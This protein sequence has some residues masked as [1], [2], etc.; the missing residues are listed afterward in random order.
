MSRTWKEYNELYYN[1]DFVPT[2]TEALLIQA[3]IF[4]YG[5]Y[6]L[7]LT[8]E[9]PKVYYKFIGRCEGYYNYYIN[10]IGVSTD[11]P[12]GND[13]LFT[14]FHELRHWYQMRVVRTLTPWTE[15]LDISGTQPYKFRRYCGQVHIRRDD[16][17]Y[18]EYNK[19]PW[20]VDANESAIKL[21]YEFHSQHL[22]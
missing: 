9:K 2:I 8:P 13:V 4:F 17:T 11:L 6:S 20:E 10:E 21:L 15:Q 7:F 18:Q 14:L 12:D 5:Y 19:L 16:L 3:E 22:K 1:F